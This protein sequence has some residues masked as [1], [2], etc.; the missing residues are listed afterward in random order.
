VAKRIPVPSL[1]ENL[2]TVKGGKKEEKEEKDERY[3][4]VER[5]HG[6]FT[7]ATTA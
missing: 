5:R 1:H 3:Y 4:R 2:L 6:A 7:R